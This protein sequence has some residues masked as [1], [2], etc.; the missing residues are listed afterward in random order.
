MYSFV[1]AATALNI[2][3]P[4]LFRTYRIRQTTVNCTIWEAA[5]A[6]C[7]APTFFKRI[8]IGMKGMEQEYIDAGLGCYNPVFEVVE[9]A[10]LAFGKGQALDC[11][12]SLGSGQ[13]GAIELK[14]PDW[15]QKI[16]PTNGLRVLERLSMDSEAT[17]EHMHAWYQK[18]SPGVYFRLNVEQG[19]NK[20]GVGDWTKLGEVTTHTAKYL[21]GRKTSAEVDNIVDT[22]IGSDGHDSAR[23]GPA[24]GGSG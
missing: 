22:I 7:A 11:V 15:I 16:L 12:L 17:A 2:A 14:K 23:V 10:D 1:C 21:Q 13:K 18:R 19:M 5:R 20:I 24:H 9:E 4:T 8:S 6:T 3:S